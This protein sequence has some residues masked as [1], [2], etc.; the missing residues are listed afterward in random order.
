MDYAHTPDAV[1][2]I[3]DA[4][5][6]NK[7]GKIITIVGCG[8]DRDPMKRPI[9]GDIATKKSDYVI[10]T[11]DNPRTEDPETIMKDILN[12]VESNNYCVIYDRKEAIL[13][14]LA[15]LEDNDTLLILGKG[16]EDYQII[17]HTKHHF[18][19]TEIVLE[20]IKTQA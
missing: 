12:G 3:I 19:D 9:M 11:N 18:D 15:M 8:G 6:E 16:H 17:G 2:K 1:S 7:T 5:L 4:F 20:Y 14:G 10:F 13:K